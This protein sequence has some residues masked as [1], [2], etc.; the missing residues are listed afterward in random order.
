M[1]DILPLVSTF[2]VLAI[3]L[4]LVVDFAIRAWRGRGKL[5]VTDRWALISGFVT[6]V[7][8]FALANLLINWVVV[9]TAL[10]L[11]AVGLLCTFPPFYQLCAAES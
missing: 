7:T 1:R 11:V 2:V 4:A 8:T 6:A 10:W 9:P 5:S 3:F